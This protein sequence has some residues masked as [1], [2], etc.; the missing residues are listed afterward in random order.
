MSVAVKGTNLVL[1]G[2]ETLDT[3]NEPISSCKVQSLSDL[4][5]I[6]REIDED[7]ITFVGRSGRRSL[8]FHA[9]ETGETHGEPNG[10]L[11]CRRGR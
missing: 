7:E 6:T 10:D 2:H 11:G 3:L 9:Y 4:V 8:R 5:S 1:E